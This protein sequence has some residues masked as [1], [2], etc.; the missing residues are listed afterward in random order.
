MN[1]LVLNSGSS[2]IKYQLLEM[3][4]T[5]L[6]AAGQ[7]ERIGEVESRLTHRRRNAE[8]KME[9]HVHMTHIRNHRAGLV[10]I[11]ELLDD[12][13]QLTA[14]GH[15]VVHAGEAFSAPIRIDAQVI[16]ILRGVSELAPLHNPA[17][18]AGI[19]VC[20]ELFP[21]IQQVAVFDT[22]F[23]QGMPAHAY[24][25]ALPN[26]LYSKHGVRRYGF[27]GTSHSYVA[28]QA[29]LHLQK[30]LE[31]LNL[32]S[33]H[34][35]NGASAAAIHGG[36][37]IDTSMGMTPMEG[38][39]MGTR[40]GDIDPAVAFYLQRVTG[41]S[42]A[43][44]E[45][46]YNHNSGLKGICGENDM[47][48]VLRMADADDNAAQLAIDIY[49]YRIKKY[50]GAYLAALGRIDGI[51]FTAGIGEN[52]PRV[53][54]LSCHGLEALGIVIDE[55]RNVRAQGDVCEIQSSNANIKLLV[56]RTNEE[57]EIARQT[58]ECIEC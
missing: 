12:T 7:I 41:Q 40:C 44:I 33:L 6:L 11:T 27:H 17:N 31:T 18:L 34:L 25:Y 22:A 19:E 37:C 20:L 49:C 56:V 53:R 46:L 10:A 9:V 36:R 47:R 35:G 48:E 8:D 55:T 58:V 54:Q 23:H 14:I 57:L 52:A 30:P 1:I 38:L 39:M 21:D 4:S 16:E 43:D 28:R 42:S 26:S 29:A 45:S 51:I 2:S 32:I 13:M 15:R 5:T 3:P 50:I 24:R